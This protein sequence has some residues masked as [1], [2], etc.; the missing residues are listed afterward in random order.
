P[1]GDPVVEALRSWRATT[2]RAAGVP[3]H[4]ILHDSTLAAMAVARPADRSALL[5]VPGIGP[6]KAERYGDALLQLVTSGH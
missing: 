1:Q 6:V 4:V 3:A 5:A 2:A